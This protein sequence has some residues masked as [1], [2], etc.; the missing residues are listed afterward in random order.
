MRQSYPGWASIDKAKR[1][2]LVVCSDRWHELLGMREYKF[3]WIPWSYLPL[4]L[5]PISP[6]LLISEVWISCVSDAEFIMWANWSLHH[7]SCRTKW[8]MARLHK[9]RGI[10]YQ[11]WQID[12]WEVDSRKL[13]QKH[14][15]KIT[16]KPPPLFHAVVQDWSFFGW[17]L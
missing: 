4:R 7:I 14:L 11:F 5:G 3:L 1:I 13:R 10:I 15:I 9:I 16:M 6:I 2:F 8:S 12:R 17:S